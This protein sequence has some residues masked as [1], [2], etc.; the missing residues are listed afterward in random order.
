[1]GRFWGRWDHRMEMGKEISLGGK[2]RDG[3][4]FSNYMGLIVNYLYY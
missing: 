4:F 1:M 3:G 2:I